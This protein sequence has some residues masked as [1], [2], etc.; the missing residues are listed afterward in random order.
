M[1]SFTKTSVLKEHLKKKPLRFY[2]PGNLAGNYYKPRRKKILQPY[3]I[4]IDVYPNHLVYIN[5]IESKE[6][7]KKPS[8]AKYWYKTKEEIEKNVF[9][10][11]FL[12]DW[13]FLLG[14]DL[15]NPKEEGTDFL[16]SYLRG[17]LPFV[18]HIVRHTI[19]TG[20]NPI[21]NKI[22]YRTHI[23]VE[24]PHQ[25]KEALVC[26]KDLVTKDVIRL[27]KGIAKVMVE[28]K[29]HLQYCSKKEWRLYKNSLDPKP[30][31]EQKVSTYWNETPVKQTEEP[32]PVVTRKS[33]IGT[34][35]VV[36]TKR[37]LNSYI[38]NTVEKPRP[39]FFKVVGGQVK[40]LPK[41]TRKPKSY[42]SYDRH[43]K[44]QYITI[45]PPIENIRLVKCTT[46]K[47]SK[48]CEEGD[49]KL[50]TITSKQVIPKYVNV[51]IYG[52]SPHNKNILFKYKK[53]FVE[54][55]EEDVTFSRPI[56][57]MYKTI[58]TKQYPRDLCERRRIIKKNME[59]LRQHEEK[60]KQE[61][62]KSK[63]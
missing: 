47:Y 31:I 10:Q 11:A 61:E 22:K 36:K 8:L 28:G 29:P 58:I 38:P 4:Q 3:N 46:N 42:P 32:K 39:L 44:K 49:I 56:R 19:K 45:E 51:P 50:E 5:H 1:R 33:K 59:L 13:N 48:L 37:I 40:L 9:W 30:R 24:H 16:W 6:L 63:T 7:L 17:S 55:V 2:L 53:L 23:L 54:N 20:I 60:Q 18:R 35:F 21:K 12:E 43:A 34:E 25:S 14:L 27:S 41:P 15:T 52:K 57:T 26:V 62:N